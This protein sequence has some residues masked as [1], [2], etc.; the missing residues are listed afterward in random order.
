MPWWSC[1]C[2][3]KDRPYE[4]GGDRHPHSLANLRGYPKFKR[5]VRR[6][7]RRKAREK[8]RAGQE[9]APRI[10]VEYEYYD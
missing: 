9:P 1:D 5:M 10:P 4:L 7:A 3:Y 6:I 8:L 2:T